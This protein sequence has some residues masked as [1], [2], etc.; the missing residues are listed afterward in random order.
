MFTD[1][2]IGQPARFGSLT[3]FPLFSEEVHAVDYLLSDEA[4]EAGVLTVG[5]VSQQGRVP[6]LTVENKVSAVLCSLKASNWSG[7]SRTAS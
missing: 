7:P 4:M 2:R 3:V 5:E 6:D 1:V